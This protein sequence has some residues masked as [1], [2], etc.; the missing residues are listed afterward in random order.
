MYGR[1][2]KANVPIWDD[3]RVGQLPELRI[4]FN[5]AKE[6][7]LQLV[8]MPSERQINILGYIC[9]YTYSA[10]H[11]WTDTFCSFSTFEESLLLLRAQAEGMRE[12]SMKNVTTPF[13]LREGVSAA[14]QNG[15]PAYLFSLLMEEF[16]AKVQL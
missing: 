7:F 5:S 9:D 1:N 11:I 2:H 8:P 3:N 10:D 14:P 16:N 12:L 13:Q 15:T 4:C 6:R